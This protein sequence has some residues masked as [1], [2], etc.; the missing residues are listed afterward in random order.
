MNMKNTMQELN[1]S[2]DKLN[3]TIN[4][5]IECNNT[6]DRIKCIEKMN[7]MKEKND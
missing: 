6:L 1:N 3:V 5:Y 4:N 7:G 2:L